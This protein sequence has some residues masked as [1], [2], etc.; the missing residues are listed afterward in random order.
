MDDDVRARGGEAGRDGTTDPRG[1]AR[2]ERRLAREDYVHLPNRSLRIG[3]GVRGAVDRGHVPRASAPCYSTSAASSRIS[4]LPRKALDTG[5]LSLA[6]MA[7]RAKA[8]AAA[9]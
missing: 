6:S 1:R 4:T 2:D 9:P 8:A 5:Q 3:C 7:A